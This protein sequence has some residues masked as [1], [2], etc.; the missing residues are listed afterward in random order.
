VLRKL[1][2]V[3]IVLLLGPDYMVAA[4]RIAGYAGSRA[5][6]IHPRARKFYDR[7]RIRLDA[8]VNT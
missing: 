3:R 5:G 8:Y 7:W 2:K 4:K 6:A 1:D